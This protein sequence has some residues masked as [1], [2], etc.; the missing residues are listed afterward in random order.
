MKTDNTESVSRG[1]T[2][3]GG[4]T[5]AAY[6]QGGTKLVRLA[7]YDYKSK[8]Q[9]MVPESIQQTRQSDKR[10]APATASAYPG[11]GV[12]GRSLHL[13]TQL[14]T[15]L[16]VAAVVRLFAQECARHVPYDSFQFSNKMD[17]VELATGS[18]ARHSC[19][20]RLVVADESLGQLTLTRALPF[21]DAEIIELEDMLVTL[22]YPL[23]NALFYQR[24]LQSALKDPLTGLYNRTA[25][26]AALLRE[27]NLAR[28]NKSALSLLVL[29]ID[30]FKIINDTHGHAAGD[31]VIKALA[32][33]IAARS[34]NTDILARFGGEEFALLLN[35]TNAAGA[36]VIAARVC[37]AVRAIVC[38]V[39]DVRIR[40]TVSVGVATLA[41]DEDEK[42][43]LERADMAMY[44]AKR[45]GRDRVC[46]AE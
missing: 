24:A 14:Q 30:N 22:V 40:F 44:L 10:I 15:S 38:Q 34:R 18:A 20:Y 6:G 31:A 41:P 26:D 39:K 2:E 12:P 37:E 21:G 17:G 19:H 33:S 36:K 35:A 43:L 8:R 4:Q 32:E 46:V 45:S 23:R 25:L 7:Q 28:R 11:A 3:A 5:G 9:Y 27:F 16:E 29:D 42:S 1:E 13:L